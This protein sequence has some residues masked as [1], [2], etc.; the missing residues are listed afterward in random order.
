LSTELQKKLQI[1]K[2]KEQKIRDIEAATLR[3]KTRELLKKQEL[4]AAVCKAKN[5]AKKEV[6]EHLKSKI[7]AT[8]PSYFKPAAR[9]V[10]HDVQR[11]I[12]EEE[13]KLRRT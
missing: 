10:L 1:I 8:A 3:L 5:D 4:E 7:P 9:A 6:L 11:V 12:S 2:E 13:K